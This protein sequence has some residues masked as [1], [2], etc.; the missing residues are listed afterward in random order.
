M[1][2]PCCAL[3]HSTKNAVQVVPQLDEGVAAMLRRQLREC[4]HARTVIAQYKELLWRW[5][6]VYWRS[7]QVLPA[8][9]QPATAP[10]MDQ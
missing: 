6:K 2:S 10:H 3:T 9:L 5:N 4:R 1:T 7:P 8:V